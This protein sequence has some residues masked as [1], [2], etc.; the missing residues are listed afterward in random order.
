[1]KPSFEVSPDVRKLVEFL[2]PRDQATY[3]EMNRLVGRTLNKRDRYVLYSALNR[4]RRDHGVVFVVETAI[5]LKARHEWTESHAFN[6]SRHPQDRENN[7]AGRKN[8]RAG[9]HPGS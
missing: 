6:R 9:Q 1:M 7:K 5:G 8:R 3:H 4:L 2:L